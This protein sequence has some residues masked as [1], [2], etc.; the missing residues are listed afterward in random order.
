MKD[1]SFYQGLLDELKKYYDSHDMK[2]FYAVAEK[3]L[4]I[5]H[6]NPVVKVLIGKEEEVIDDKKEVSK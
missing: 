6:G 4:R 1:M 5:K 2:Q 3:V